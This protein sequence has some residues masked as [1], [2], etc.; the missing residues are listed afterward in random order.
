MSHQIS[1]C[2]R[3]KSNLCSSD[4]YTKFVVRCENIMQDLHVIGSFS[5]RFMRVVF[6]NSGHYEIDQS[7]VKFI[8]FFGKSTGTQF[9]FFVLFQLSLFPKRSGWRTR[10]FGSAQPRVTQKGQRKPGSP[11]A[12]LCPWFQSDGFSRLILEKWLLSLRI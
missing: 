6:E 5:E 4:T 10:A 1:Q 11:H 9:S 8:E 12:F 3:L 7:I 2:S